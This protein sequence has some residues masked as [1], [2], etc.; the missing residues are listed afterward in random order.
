MVQ[1]RKVSDNTIVTTSA[2]AEITFMTT[3]NSVYV[4]ERAAKPLSMYTY[5]H[6]GGTLNQDG[7]RLPSTTLTL[8]VVTLP[9][10]DTGKYEG[11]S[12]VMT[13]MCVASATTP[14]RGSKR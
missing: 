14:R 5:A 4:I 1:V 11:E 6:V 9:A 12:G 3:A 2:S 13:G 7:K 10:P 8:G